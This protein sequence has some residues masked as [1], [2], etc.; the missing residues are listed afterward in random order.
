[1]GEHQQR[2]D[3][4]TVEANRGAT[5][6]DERINLLKDSSHLDR[7]RVGSLVGLDGQVRRLQKNI[8]Q[9]LTGV[10]E[11]AVG[12]LHAPGHPNRRGRHSRDVKCMRGSKLARG[13]CTNLVDDY[14]LS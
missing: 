7:L 5:V 12:P 9:M 14:A 13:A 8:N 4:G 2:S 6:T 1:M 3:R 11:P 10:E